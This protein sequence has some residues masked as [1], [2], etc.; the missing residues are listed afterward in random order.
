MLTPGTPAPDFS[1]PDQTGA[2]RSLAELRTGRGAPGGAGRGLV[3]YFYPADFTPV[4]TKEAC[5]FRDVYSQLAD[6]GLSVAGISPQSVESHAK[7]AAKHAL[8]YPLLA[9]T[10][11]QAIRAYGASALFGLFTRRLTY[12]VDAS[13][14]ITASINAA[15]DLSK[16]R[17]LIDRALAGAR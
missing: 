2:L 4:C 17:A 14:V 13:G 6:A 7:F 8:P 11:G 10:Q 1:L 12:V 3:L 9:D 5:M 15:L 16:H